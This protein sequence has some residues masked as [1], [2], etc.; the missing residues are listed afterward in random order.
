MVSF[1]GSS[2]WAHPVI[3]KNGMEFIGESQQRESR[4][5]MHYSFSP[6]WSV[7]AEY[8][9]FREDD[10]QVSSLQVNHILKRWNNLGSQ[11][12]IYVTLGGGIFDVA[13]SKLE[14][15]WN[16]GVQADWEST[17]YY[18]ESKYSHIEPEK[19]SALDFKSLRLG[20]APYIPHQEGMINTW[21]IL[22][23]TQWN[24]DRIQTT[25]MFRFFYQNVL[26]EIG[27]SLDGDWL[28]QFMIHN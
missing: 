6:K 26:F 19:H 21:F 3:Y 8:Y 11:A 28:F 2:V 1:F 7:G 27:H 24:R 14:G 16:G 17:K 15:Q 10:V 13:D 9:D 5:N 23:W 18:I 20:F 22:Q 25:P 4:Y 12:N